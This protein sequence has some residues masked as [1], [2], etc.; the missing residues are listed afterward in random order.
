MNCSLYPLNCPLCPQR[1]SF[2]SRDGE[3]LL[4]SCPK[5]GVVVLSSDARIWVDEPPE[6][7]P[8]TQ[9]HTD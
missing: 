6:P 5:H 9:T 4:Y 8:L 1:L 7:H 3:L 2:V